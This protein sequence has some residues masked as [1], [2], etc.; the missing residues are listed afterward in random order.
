MKCCGTPAE[1]KASVGGKE[2]TLE[3]VF[4]HYVGAITE[5]GDAYRETTRTRRTARRLG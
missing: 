1:L 3:Q 2:V 4:V 5:S